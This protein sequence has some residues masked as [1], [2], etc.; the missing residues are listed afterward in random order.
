MITVEMAAMLTEPVPDWVD[1]S[2]RRGK[3]GITLDDIREGLAAIRW[4]ATTKPAGLLAGL[5]VVQ[6]MASPT[7]AM[8]FPVPLEGAFCRAA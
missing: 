8:W 3:E 6:R 4:T 7:G 5:S 2:D 1:P